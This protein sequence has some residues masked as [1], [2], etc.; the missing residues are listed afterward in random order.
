MT[1]EFRFILLECNISQHVVEVHMGIYDIANRQGGCMFYGIFKRMADVDG[2]ARVNDSDT[3]IACYK[4]DIGDVVMVNMIH[5]DVFPLVNVNTPADLGQ[6]ERPG[7]FRAGVSIADQRKYQP[8]SG[9]RNH[10]S[11]DVDA[12][13][14]QE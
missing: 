14:H 12:S 11:R 4:A 13:D 3:F 8:C 2:T 1:D 7:I 6:V 9:D 5:V 10:N